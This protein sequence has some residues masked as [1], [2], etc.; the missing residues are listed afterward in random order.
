MRKV[1]RVAATMAVGM[2]L[3]SCSPRPPVVNV[4]PRE[5]YAPPSAVSRV[6]LPPPVGY[7]QPP[8]V[9]YDKYA[10]AE[11]ALPPGAHMVWRATPPWAVGKGAPRTSAPQPDSQAKFK[12]AEAKAAKVGVQNLT[13]EDVDGLTSAQLKQLRGY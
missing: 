11:A 3:L 9:P 5:A 4:P 6:P 7:A 12:A 2:T 8:S 1:R 10:R 13:N